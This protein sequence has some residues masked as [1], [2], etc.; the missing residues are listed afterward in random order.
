VTPLLSVIVVLYNMAREGRRT[1]HSLSP[2]YQR[3]IAADDYEVIVV[4][5]GST[6]PFPPD[7][8]RAHGGRFESLYL[9]GA[10]PSPA[11]AVNRG[12]RASR[13]RYL[14]IVVDGARMAS[15]GLL[16]YALRAFRA[17]DNPVITAPAWHLGPDVHRRAVERFGHT[18]AM[19]DALLERIRWPEDGYRLFEIAALGGSSADGW[20]GPM[21]ESSSLFLTRES[22]ERLGGYDERFDRPGGGLLNTDTYVRA[23]GLPDADLVVLLGEGTFHQM[24][25]GI[26]TGASTS[27]AARQLAEWSAQYTEIRG[28]APAAPTRAPHYIG[29]VPCSARPSLLAS[30][31][32]SVA[33]LGD[34]S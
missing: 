4:D 34:P 31:Q 24:H 1:L 11:A 25:G 12:V 32:R 6:P 26:M 28:T 18:Q 19:E 17:F 2:A 7:L 16:G 14:G 29:H 22:F 33:R 10:S 21:S 23:C 13:G 5:N 20:L 3:G 15:P 9:E 8:V 30:A 27:G